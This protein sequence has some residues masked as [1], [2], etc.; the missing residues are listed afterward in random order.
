MRLSGKMLINVEGVN[1]WKYSNQAYVYEG[2]QNDIYLQL[3]D[4]A[5]DPSI[6]P[7]SKNLPENPMRYIPQGTT[8]TASI[9]FPSVDNNQE[10][11]VVG[12]QPFVDDKSIWK[13]TLADN[14]LPGTGYARLTLTEDGS[15]KTVNLRN[16]INVE[17]IEI[18]SC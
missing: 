11:T 2:Q 15:S 13:F 10:I 6:T 8:V 14:Q 17:T 5:K 3:V 12:S 4:V 7:V 1:T 16:V 9:K 18:G